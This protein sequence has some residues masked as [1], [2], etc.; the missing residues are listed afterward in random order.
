MG[1]ARF[2][3]ARAIPLTASFALT[4]YLAIA[5]LYWWSINLQSN[6]RLKIT[7]HCWLQQNHVNLTA[8]VQP[9]AHRGKPKASRY[10]LGVIVILL[11]VMYLAVTAKPAQACTRYLLTSMAQPHS[12]H[13]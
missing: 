9:N 7:A 12:R 11:A 8:I 1:W 13:L 5:I 3:I 6:T 10:S 4:T 2:I